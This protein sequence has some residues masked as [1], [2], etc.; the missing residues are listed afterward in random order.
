MLSL[1]TSNHFIAA[2]SMTL[3]R[4]NIRIMAVVPWLGKRKDV[5]TTL[6]PTTDA[7]RR[8]REK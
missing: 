4:V 6:W 7:G 1:L 8:G 2:S 5:A 3:T